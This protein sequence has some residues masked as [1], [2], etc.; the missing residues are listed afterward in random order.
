[1]EGPLSEGG[2]D[3]IRQ[4]TVSKKSLRCLSARKQQP[5]ETCAENM[6]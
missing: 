3:I 1:M 5:E 2:P 4:S 6:D